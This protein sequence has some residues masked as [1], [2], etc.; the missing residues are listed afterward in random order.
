MSIKNWDKNKRL[1]QYNSEKAMI[2]RSKR[3]EHLYFTTV[4][5]QKC[6]HSLMYAYQVVIE[7]PIA[8]WFQYS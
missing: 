1:K 7:I 5:N 8:C 2:T 6:K 4:Q 3:K